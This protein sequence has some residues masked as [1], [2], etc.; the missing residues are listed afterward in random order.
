[1]IAESGQPARLSRNSHVERLLGLTARAHTKHAAL[2]KKWGNSQEWL[3]RAGH[4][5]EA[6]PGAGDRLTKERSEAEAAVEARERFEAEAIRES[7]L[8]IR[9]VE[10]HQ[11]AIPEAFADFNSVLSKYRAVLRPAEAID[12][13]DGAEEV[14]ETESPDTNAPSVPTAPTAPVDVPV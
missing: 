1:V 9:I 5:L 11:D 7:N 12:A 6:I 8:A 3:T 13:S 10:V 4:L 14:E 2:L